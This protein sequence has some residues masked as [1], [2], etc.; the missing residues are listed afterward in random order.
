MQHF[1]YDRA[2]QP[3][4][5][6]RILQQQP[7]VLPLAVQIARACERYGIRPTRLGRDAVGDPRLY[8]DMVRSGRQPGERV[9]AKVAA[10][11]VDLEGRAGHA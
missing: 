1:R 11:L 4:P 6:A 8:H 2:R 10:F 3:M 7:A 5:A 9:R